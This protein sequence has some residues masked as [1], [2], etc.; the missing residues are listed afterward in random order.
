[1]FLPGAGWALVAG[2]FTAWLLMLHAV[3]WHT[4][5]ANSDAANA[6]LAGHAMAHGNVLLTGWRLPVDTYWPMDLGLY[7]IYAAVAGVGPETVHVVPLATFVATLGMSLALAAQG[8]HEWRRIAGAGATFLIVGL[9]AHSL[10][11]FVLQGPDHIATVF[12]CL[13]ALL[14][15]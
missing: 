3:S 4:F 15:L 5:A 14:L 12:L 9:P 10:A 7:A 8:A 11:H 13:G 6:A 1:S 2:A